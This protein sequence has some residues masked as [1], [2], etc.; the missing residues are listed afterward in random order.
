MRQKKIKIATLVELEVMSGLVTI[1]TFMLALL[2]ANSNFTSY[3]YQDVISLPVTVRF[4]TL[5]FDTTIRHIINDGLITLFFLF[6]GKNLQ[7]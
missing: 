6:I 4:G 5:S 2:M 3:F 7:R 1:F